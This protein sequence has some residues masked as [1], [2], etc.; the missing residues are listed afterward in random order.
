MLYQLEYSKT[1]AAIIAQARQWGEPIP[2]VILNKP[3]LEQG[4]DLY[5]EAFWTLS[6]C[7]SIGMGLGPIPWDA[8]EK[9]GTILALDADQSDDLEYHIGRLDSAFLSW[10][11]EHQKQGAAT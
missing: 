3:E 8:V 6:S 10:S 7:R 2:D 11:A 4:L 1:E 5:L 9:Y